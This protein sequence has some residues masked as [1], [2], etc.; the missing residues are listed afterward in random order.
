MNHC[1]ATTPNTMIQVERA[2]ISAILN[3]SHAV[4][5]AA[6]VIQPKHFSDQKLRR[7]Y[8][9]CCD[10][11]V[12][13]RVP[14]FTTVDTE[15]QG[16]YT[17]DLA[18]LL[19][20]VSTSATIR[21]HADLMKA[22][23]VERAT[24]QLLHNIP[25]GLT[26]YELFAEIQRRMAAIESEATTSDLLDPLVNVE[27]LEE[28]FEILRNPDKDKA[29]IL[30]SGLTELDKIIGG[31]E[32]PS[33]T[34]IQ[35][36]FKAGK[37]KLLLSILC[38]TAKNKIPVGFLSLEMPKKKVLR[39]V[40]SHVAQ[41]DSFFFKYPASEKWADKR[42]RLIERMVAHVGTLTHLPF[43]VSDIRRPSIDQ[44]GAIIAQ[45]ARAGVQM[46]GLDYF[47]RMKLPGDWN[48]EGQITSK[49]ADIAVAHNVALIYLDQL[50]KTAEHN[51]KT[52]LGDS[53]GSIA[54]SADA[55][56]IIQIKNMSSRE[57]KNVA[58]HM[59][60][61]EM[62]I[63]ERDG[64]SGDRLELRA[65]LSTGEFRGRDDRFE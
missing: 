36:L 51:T 43:Y 22:A 42:E 48:L 54:R 3:Y 45:W 7:I 65:D 4:E 47:E 41:I 11:R 57:R 49:L 14:D 6:E 62:L 15:L 17:A 29:T 26:G 21:Q 37:T 8:K 64:S 34:T 56:L 18:E 38:R 55:D 25:E 9:A 2:V 19:T 35:G 20:V 44:V 60:D 27:R 28:L 13:Q 53:R 10:I 61:I 12:D 59:A 39:W 46:V 40:I 23:Y 50:N 33:V 63:V 32:R 58:S 5:I 52:S 24:M 31:F 1:S 30:P 16:K